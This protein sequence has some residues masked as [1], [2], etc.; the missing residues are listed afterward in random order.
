MRSQNLHSLEY[1]ASH[2]AQELPIMAEMRRDLEQVGLL[3]MAVSPVEGA[4]LA[5]FARSH[6]V[7]KVVEIGTLYGYSTLW[8]ARALP[9][10]GRIWSLDVEAE[11]SEQAR[12]YAQKAGLAEFIEFVSGPALEKLPELESH[13]PFDLVFID[14]DKAAYMDYLHWADRHLK[15]GGLM[16]G[17]NTFL[18]GAV[19]DQP[20]RANFS[21]GRAVEVMKEFNS[22]LASSP[23]YNSIMIPTLEGMTV[24]VKK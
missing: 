24:A 20:T 14:A 13:G 11:R 6:G 1:I 4:L 5:F 16:I 10:E 17:D 7:K 8:L 15:S 19:Y 22:W 23:S 3:N 18:F 21:Q 2:F 9:S 12:T